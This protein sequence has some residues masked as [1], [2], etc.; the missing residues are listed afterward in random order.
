MLYSGYII[1]ITVTVLLNLSKDELKVYVDEFCCLEG[2]GGVQYAMNLS[3]LMIMNDATSIAK[4]N[5][6]IAKLYE[7]FTIWVT[8][9]RRKT[10]IQ[11]IVDDNE[12]N[13]IAK[14]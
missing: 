3:L 13:L 10:K 11:G 6:E 4:N 12:Y 14:T 9:I 2:Y 7:R 8:P 5:P 1:K